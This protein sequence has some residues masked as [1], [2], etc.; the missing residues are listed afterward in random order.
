MSAA[1]SSSG[2]VATRRP[3]RP[4][5]WY[6]F[7]ALKKTSLNALHHAAGA[8]MTDIAGWA[9]PLEFAG[10]ATEQEAVRTTAGLFD[11]SHLGELEVAGKDALT[12]L[13]QAFS[14]DFSA[15]KPGHAQHAGDVLVFRLKNDHFMVV[16]NPGRV[17]ETYNAIAEKAGSLGDAVAFD[18]SSRYTVIA[19]QGPRAQRMVQPLTGVDLSG[20]EHGDFAHG[21]FANVRGTISRAGIMGGDGFEIFIPPQQADRVWQSLVDNGAVPCGFAASDTGGAIVCPKP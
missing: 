4:S 11:V 12:A 5:A 20:L 1:T 13:N 16:T 7:R 14:T 15:L 17:F 3:R 21:E 6:T 19:V 18:A 2:S 10:T 9:M 8:K